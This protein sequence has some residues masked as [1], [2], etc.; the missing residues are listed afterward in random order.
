MR[1]FTV[2]VDNCGLPE[3]AKAG[4]SVQATQVFRSTVTITFLVFYLS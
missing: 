3:I 2:D 1:S 4:F